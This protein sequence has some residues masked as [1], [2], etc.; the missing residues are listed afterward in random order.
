L[1]GPAR[2]RAANQFGLVAKRSEEAIQFGLDAGPVAIEKPAD[3]HDEIEHPPKAEMP[4]IGYMACAQF[5]AM[6][7]I[8]CSMGGD[9]AREFRIP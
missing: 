2:S 9:V 4:C 1:E 8:P 5:S 7:G 6:A 3:E